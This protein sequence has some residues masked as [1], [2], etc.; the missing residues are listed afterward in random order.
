MDWWLPLTPGCTYRYF[1]PPGQGEILRPD[2]KNE[3]PCCKIQNTNPKFRDYNLHPASGT[4]KPE[5]SAGI[6]TFPRDGPT[7]EESQVYSN[8]QHPKNQR[9]RRGRIASAYG[10]RITHD[11]GL[12]PP[13][14]PLSRL[15]P[16]VFRLQSPVFRLPSSVFG[17]P[18]SASR[19]PSS[20]FCL[21]SPVFRLRSSG[22]LLTPQGSRG[23]PL[24]PG[25]FRLC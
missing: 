24:S 23:L 16:P 11:F 9:P 19:L 18:S 1:A 3:S 8:K 4:R 14:P 7:P 6:S 20:V 21:R 12:C 10:S 25:R 13:L 5:T 22:S 2:D 17:L 15:L